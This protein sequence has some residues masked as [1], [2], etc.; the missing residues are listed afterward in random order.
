ME[1]KQDVVP[2]QKPSF[3]KRVWNYVWRNKWWFIAII[4]VA[5]R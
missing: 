1:E 2:Q 5:I 4:I 3:I